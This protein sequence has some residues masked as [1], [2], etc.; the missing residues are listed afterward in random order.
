MDPLQV[1]LERGGVDSAFIEKVRS[2]LQEQPGRGLESVLL[3]AGLTPEETRDFFADY[4]QV[5]S[6]KI[7]EGFSVKQEILNYIRKSLLLTTTLYLS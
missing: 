6:F 5:P 7:P 1:L 2:L 3:E 4:F